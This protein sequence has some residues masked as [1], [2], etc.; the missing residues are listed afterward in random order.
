VIPVGVPLDAALSPVAAS[1]IAGGGGG[2]PIL[3]GG[4]GGSPIL[5]GAPSAE[6]EEGAT[7]YP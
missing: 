1:L 2:S 5:G 7:S 6:G 4:G 3:G